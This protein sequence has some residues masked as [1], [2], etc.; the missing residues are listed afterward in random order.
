MCMRACV[1]VCVCVL[2]QF[3]FIFFLIIEVHIYM[4]AMSVMYFKGAF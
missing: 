3:C 4:I 1:R 2:S